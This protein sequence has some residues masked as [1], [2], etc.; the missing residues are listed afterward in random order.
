MNTH[1]ENLLKDQAKRKRLQKTG[2]TLILIMLSSTSVGFL[3][4]E[5]QFLVVVLML[6]V[7]VGLFYGF[8]EASE[9]DPEDADGGGDKAL[10]RS[11]FFVI[12]IVLAGLYALSF[13]LEAVVETENYTVLFC[14]ILVLILCAYLY[15]N[16]DELTAKR[17]PAIWRLE[18]SCGIC[19][20]G[21]YQDYQYKC[22]LCDFVSSDKKRYGLA[23]HMTQT[24]ANIARDLPLIKSVCSDCK[25]RDANYK[26]ISKNRP[27]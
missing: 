6:G 3:V 1:T 7:E 22:P 18:Y 10:G 4:L 20:T 27:L 2:T 5:P 23:R 21:A 17:Y 11:I 13:F 16:I 15:P 12:L 8:M 19:E 24:H 25:S 14:Y 9:F 26:K